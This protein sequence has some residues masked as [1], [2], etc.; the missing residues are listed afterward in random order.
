MKHY[1]MYI[2]G[3]WMDTSGT[4][5]E[6]VNPADQRVIAT[7]PDGGAEEAK[8][9]VSAAHEAFVAWSG[10]S[11]YERAELLQAW[12][13]LIKQHEKDLAE[14]ITT[15][16]GKPFK[17]ALGE[18]KYANGFL[19]WYAEEAKRIYGE[20]IPAT[21]QDKRLFVIKQPV[22]V[23]AAITPWNFPAAMIMRKIAPALAAGCTAVCKPANMTPIT[24]LKL[25]QL[26]EKAGLPKGVLNLV[27]GD[28]SA[29][30][31]A[32]LADERVRKITFTGSTEVGKKLMEGAAQ[33]VKK[34]SL[35]L[36]GHAPLL[37]MEDADLDKAVKGV[38]DSKFRNSGQTCICSNRVYVQESISAEFMRKLIA[39]VK[40]LKWGD[41]MKEGVDMG[42]LINEDAVEKVKRHIADAV[43]QGTSVE[44]GGQPDEALFFEPTVLSN[45]TD[46]MLCMKEET[47]GPVVP[48][49]TFS[50]DQEAI[51]R[52]NAVPYGLAAYVF[53]ENISRGIRVTEAL[54]Y[55]IIGLN[56][57]LPST[58]QAPF[59]GF[60]ESGIGREGGRQG[61]EEFLEVKYISL[62]M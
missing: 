59:G 46:D 12:H 61:I 13:Q 53:T 41:G 7:V 14:T 44:V 38:I 27:T 36:G 45:V 60:K 37:I 3:K 62:G 20:T 57:G 5:K 42:P 33:T 10:Y 9:A 55:G 32:W 16:Q 49:S 51:N 48:V 21:Q 25:A 30:G 6:I 4:K 15:E 17:E 2:N 58:P 29:I 8:L 22:G 39:A 35:E 26:A 19:A 11:A 28:S 24:A 34:V 31:K 40:Q 43:N 18:I 52:A 1:S 47:F 23:I 56:D 54:E 50:D